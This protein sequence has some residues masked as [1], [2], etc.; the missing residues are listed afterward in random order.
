MSSILDALNKLEKEKI[1][2]ERKAAL[3][4]DIDIETAARD[5]VGRSLLRDRFTLQLSP[6]LLLAGVLIASLVLVI[7]GVGASWAYFRPEQPPEVAF[8]NADPSNTPSGPAAAL[9]P[10]PAPEEQTSPPDQLA[11]Q[12]EVPHTPGPAPPALIE[13]PVANS[14]DETTV[15]QRV[16]PEPPVVLAEKPT[17]PVVVETPMNE[18]PVEDPAPLVEE[19]VV[20]QETV[21]A[22]VPEEPK[23]SNALDETTAPVV[24]VAQEPSVEPPVAPT[25]SVYTEPKP[26]N[27]LP[28]FSTAVRTRHEIPKLRVNHI[29]LGDSTKPRPFAWINNL[30]VY[31]GERIQSSKARLKKVAEGGVAI[32]IIGTRELYYL[33]F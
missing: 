13:E 30:K 31:P 4:K 3:E 14:T 24:P 16:D 11:I 15:S 22:T 12:E 18:S 2:A 1:R 27:Y 20:A 9:P 32:E 33:K 23:R 21:Q 25:G 8:A 17:D 28:A 19:L 6:A 29:H 10:A 26:I 5:L 7:S